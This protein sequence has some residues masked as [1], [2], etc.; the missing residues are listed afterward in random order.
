MI[1]CL[2]SEMAVKPGEPNTIQRTYAEMERMGVVETRRGQG[3]FVVEN[4]AIVHNLK[5]SMKKEIIQQFVENMKNIG[6]TKEEMIKNLEEYFQTME[7]L[8]G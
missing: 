8:D 1:N 4:Q 6:F 3:T 5:E 7:N 2:S